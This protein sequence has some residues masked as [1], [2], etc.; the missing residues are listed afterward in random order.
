MPTMS[1]TEG[2]SRRASRNRLSNQGLKRST[3]PTSRTDQETSSF[4][5]D[6]SRALFRECSKKAVG[7][8]S[9]AGINAH[10]YLSKAGQTDQDLTAPDVRTKL[11][12]EMEPDAILWG[13]VS[14]NQGVAM[15]DVVMRGVSGKDLL[16]Q[17]QYMEKLN[18]E[19][20]ADL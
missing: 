1:L 12:S 20:R 18:T 3:S 15:I 10:R 11:A 8:Q 17:A 4:W 2:A 19:L 14:V 16:F 9:S 5:E 7:L 13:K 6:F